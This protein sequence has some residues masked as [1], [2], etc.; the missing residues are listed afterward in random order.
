VA[1]EQIWKALTNTTELKKW[2]CPKPWRVAQVELDPRPGGIFYTKMQGPNGESPDAE[3]GCV[4]EAIPGRKLVWTSAMGPGFRPLPKADGPGA[5]HFTA[6]IL[7]EP[8]GKGSKYTAIAIHTDE[9]SK[10]VHEQMGFQ[11]GWGAAFDQ[12]VELIKSWK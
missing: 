3:A 4:L 10:S 11:D 2:F 12:M 1:P 8:Q 5:F 6:V 9:A 7:I